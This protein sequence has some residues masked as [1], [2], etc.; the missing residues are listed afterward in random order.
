MADPISHHRNPY[1]VLVAILAIAGMAATFVPWVHTPTHG[2]I[3]GYLG[4][5]VLSGGLFGVVFFLMVLPRVSWLFVSGLGG[6][7]AAWAVLFILDAADLM[8]A[9]PGDSHLGPG[10]VLAGSCGVLVFVVAAVA[11]AAPSRT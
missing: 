9:V 3:P 11:A 7:A 8:E 2:A 4:K 6:A 10:P 1:R 5:G